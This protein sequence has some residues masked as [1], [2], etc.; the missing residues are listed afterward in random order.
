L[1]EVIEPYDTNS[2]PYCSNRRFT[3][4]GTD[5]INNIVIEFLSE[6]P[7]ALVADGVDDYVKVADTPIFTDYTV[8][9]KR[10]ILSELDGTFRAFAAKMTNE[11]QGAFILERQNTVNKYEIFNFGQF[12]YL[13]EIPIDITYM[14]SN[15]Y[16]GHPIAKGNTIDGDVVHIFSRRDD[17]CRR[18]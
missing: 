14:T 11:P 10:K 8:I 13:T 16:N 1:N 3:V 12:T 5:I 4:K 17:G 7:N 18:W 9:A 6:Y 15:S 2:T